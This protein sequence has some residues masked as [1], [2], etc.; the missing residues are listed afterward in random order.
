[1]MSTSHFFQFLSKNTLA[2]ESELEQLLGHCARKK[3]E[4]GS[5]LVREGDNPAHSFFVENGLL[6]QY[7]VDANGKEHI[8]QFAPENWFMSIRESEFFN[9]S[10]P[11]FVEAIEDTEVFL[12]DYHFVNKLS[13]QDES[14]LKFS[15]R[16]L[17]THILHLQKR[18]QMLQSASAETRYL[19]FIQV[20]PD[21]LMRVPQ[22]MVASYLGIT[23]ESLSRV[24]KELARK[25]F[26]PS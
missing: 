20:Y 23:P 7:S 21:I 5:I 13:T 10:S 19:D 15:H 16:L 12:I 18:I 4:K 1:M 2:K 6:R 22:S 11:Y 24:R 9:Q 8:L 14:F 25:N 26:Q 3:Y 17:Q